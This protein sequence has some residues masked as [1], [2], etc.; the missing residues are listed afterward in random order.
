MLVVVTS[1]SLLVQI[2]SQGYMEGDG[3]YWRYYAYLSL[4]TASMLGLVLV[5]SL[6]LVYVFWEMVAFAR[7]CSSASGSTGRRPRRRRRRR[8]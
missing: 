7:T 6:V 5:N 2:Y 8:S 4:F 3:G 1:V